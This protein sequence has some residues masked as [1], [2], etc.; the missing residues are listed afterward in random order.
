MIRKIDL[1]DVLFGGFLI[2]AAAGTLAAT[3]KLSV[4][5]AADMGPGY[6]PRAISFAL[7]AFGAFFAGRGLLRP[8]RGIEA[9]RLRP[10]V[11]V[12]GGVAAFALLAES[13]GLA[14]A[15][16]ASVVIASF[17]GPEQRP[18]ETLVFAVALTAA[19]ILLFVRLLGLPVPVWPW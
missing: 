2:L 16:L 8:F 6:M 4:G 18:L 13:A 7:I 12:L 5:S 1:P 14:L 3:W 19:A 15:S 9:I 17:G 11:C 10:L